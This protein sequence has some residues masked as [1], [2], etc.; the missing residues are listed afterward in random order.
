M[1]P[2]TTAPAHL[3]WGG[4]GETWSPI[5]LPLHP[6]HSGLCAPHLVSVQIALVKPS[7]QT[8]ISA[9]MPVANVKK[10][11]IEAFRRL[12]VTRCSCCDSI[13]SVGAFAHSTVSLGLHYVRETLFFGLNWSYGLRMFVLHATRTLPL[14]WAWLLPCR[15]Q[16]AILFLS[17]LTRSGRFPC[18]HRAAP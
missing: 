12:V 11:F 8:P 13:R 15:Q 16:A 18:M 2:H 3:S 9:K 7:R 10:R 17:L 6:T 4:D 5:G 14:V 1:C